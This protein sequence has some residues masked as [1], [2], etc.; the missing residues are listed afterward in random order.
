MDTNHLRQRIERET[1]IPTVL[2]D[3]YLITTVNK[4]NRRERD[5]RSVIRDTV[6]AEKSKQMI[7]ELVENKEDDIGIM[8]LEYIV[9]DIEK[10]DWISEQITAE[11][12]RLPYVLRERKNEQD[13]HN[14]DEAF[15]VAEYAISTSWIED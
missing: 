6:D 1:Q 4:S 2:G 11:L 3:E 8:R 10:G 14:G 12:E 15:Y 5:P 9:T 7:L 13:A